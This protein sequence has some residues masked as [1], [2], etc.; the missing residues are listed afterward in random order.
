[1]GGWAA[2]NLKKIFGCA[3]AAQPQQFR[4]PTPQLLHASHSDVINCPC[5]TPATPKI[6]PM[7]VD[8][9]NSNTQGRTLTRQLRH[10]TQ[11]PPP[12]FHPCWMAF[13]VRVVFSL[14]GPWPTKFGL[15]R[16]PWPQKLQLDFFL[17]QEEPRKPRRLSRG[18][19]LWV[20]GFGGWPMCGGHPPPRPERRAVRRKRRARRCST[21]PRRR[22]S[23]CRACCCRSGPASW[24]GGGPER[25]YRLE[26][27]RG[28]SVGVTLQAF[29]GVV[30]HPSFIKFTLHPL[31]VILRPAPAG[32]SFWTVH[33]KTPP[34]V[35]Q[36]C[37]GFFG[38]NGVEMA[39]SARTMF[40]GT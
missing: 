3:A 4:R 27:G 20:V 9:R 39:I 18:W 10:L 15:G 25:R 29:P 13:W 17:Q 8:T 12:V 26:G 34:I 35:T 5:R 24:P 37:T 19:R 11:V 30:H 32:L 22:L 16:V 38:P 2:S 6:C 1:M 28:C 31:R 14:V 40:G 21:S 36:A 33:Y 7:R 23:A